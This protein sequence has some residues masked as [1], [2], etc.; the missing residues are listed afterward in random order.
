[1]VLAYFQ[2]LTFAV[3]RLFV[4]FMIWQHSAQKLF[5]MF[6]G[7]QAGIFTGLWLLGLLEFVGSLALAMGFLARPIAAVLA[8]ELLV[9]YLIH[10][11]PLGFPPYG[12]RLGEQIVTLA[13]ASGFLAFAGPGRFSVD[14]DLRHEH[15]ELDPRWFGDGLHKYYPQALGAFRI[16][17]ALLFL[18]HGLPKMGI[19]GEA[20]DLL[21][22]RWVAGVVETFGGLAIALGLF[23]RPAAFISSGQMAFAYFLSHGP[24]GFFPIENAGDR[25]AL[26]CFFFLCLV[27][28]GAGCWALDGWLHRRTRRTG[29]AQVS[30]RA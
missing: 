1:V 29:K 28:A 13:F 8:V 16:L 24:R 12:G 22:Q 30:V 7:E 21:T 25:A 20:A 11:L 10:Y 27:P 23:T 26:F 2:P 19:G 5:G 3:L 17:F 9:L 4:A 14:A 6:G 18:Q 15:P